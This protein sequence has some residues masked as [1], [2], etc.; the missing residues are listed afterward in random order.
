MSHPKILV[1]GATG[2]IGKAVAEALIK[3]NVPFRA[4]VHD[5]AKAEFLTSHKNIEVVQVDLYKVESVAKALDGIEKVFLMTPPGGT[6]ASYPIIEEAK[7]H[8]VKHIVK[9]SALGA[10]V[11]DPT[12]FVWAHEHRLVEEAIVKAGIAITSLRPSS[13][14]SNVFQDAHLIKT[15]SV[16]YKS[17]GSAKVNW[18]ANSDIGEVAA[19]ALTTPG[20]EGKYYSITGPE[21]YDWNQVVQIFR[22]AGKHVDLVPI[23]DEQF[24]ES[25]KAFLPPQ[26]VEPYSNLYQYLKNGGY[27]VHSDDLEKVTGSKG[28]RLEDFIKE[29]IQA[30]K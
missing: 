21:N 1:L 2:N 15:K 14:F 7:K 5:V 29:N 9:L 10:E 4:G 24:K 12:K 19:T 13:F 16:I 20:H 17:L 27:N 18:I 26:A 22:D 28:R 6:L 23:T 25:S 3:R 30:F 11:E 8:H